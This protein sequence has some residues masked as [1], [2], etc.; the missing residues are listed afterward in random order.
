VAGFD[1]VAGGGGVVGSVEEV[2]VDA[3]GGVG[4]RVAELPGDEDDVEAARDQE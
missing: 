2:G 1:G 3:E 4:V